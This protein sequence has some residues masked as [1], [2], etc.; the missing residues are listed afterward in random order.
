MC[1]GREQWASHHE[2]LVVDLTHVNV[3]G[4]LATVVDPAQ[5]NLDMERMAESRRCDDPMGFPRKQLDAILRHYRFHQKPF[6]VR[7]LDTVEDNR[8]RASIDYFEGVRATTVRET[9]CQE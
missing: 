4:S 9:S 8:F 7:R 5:N 3:T 1:P 2:A 6:C